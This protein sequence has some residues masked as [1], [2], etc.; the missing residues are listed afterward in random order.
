[1]HV[2]APLLA[3]VLLVLL[4]LALVAGTLRVGAE[5]DPAVGDGMDC[6]RRLEQMG[7][8]AQRVALPAGGDRQCAIADP[9]ALASVAVQSRR[10]DFLERPL[11][12]CAMAE[13]LARFMRDIAAPLALGVFGKELVVVATGPGYDC[14]P[15][16]RQPGAKLSSHGQGLAIDIADFG[17]NGGR[18][19][20]IG[21]DADV[22]TAQFLAGFRAAACGAFHTVLG[23]GADTAHANHIHVDIEPRGRDGRSKFCQ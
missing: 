11:L 2:P 22:Q 5:P 10:I 3:A 21:S 7:V 9:V 20:R 13:R 16:N 8:A 19:V 4:I 17:L 14:R 6:I 12:A 15:R 23:P 1:M 18:R